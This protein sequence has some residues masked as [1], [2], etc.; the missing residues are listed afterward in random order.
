MALQFDVSIRKYIA[1]N[2]RPIMYKLV[3]A[4]EFIPETMSTSF[5]ARSVFDDVRKEFPDLILKFSSDNPRNP[6][7]QAGPKELEIIKYLNSNPG[8]QKWEGQLTIDGKPYMAKFSAMRMKEECLHCHGEPADAPASLLERY[9]PTAGFHRPLNEVVALDTVAI[10]MDKINNLLWA[11]LRNNIMAIVATVAILFF[12]IVGVFKYLINNRLSMI[13]QHF[14]TTAGQEDYLKIEPLEVKGKD[15]ISSL[16][17]SFN[18]LATKIHNYNVSL[19]DEITERKRVEESLI[20][21]SSFLKS[22]IESLNHPFF[23]INTENYSVLIANE[24]SNFKQFEEEATCY[25]LTHYKNEPCSGKEHP[26]PVKEVKKRRQPVILE[27]IHYDRAG[28][29][30]VIEIHAHPIF[31]SDGSINKIIE[32]TLDITDR[33]K[34]EEEK[35]KL[36]SQLQDALDKVKTLSGF[37]PICASCKKIRDDKGYWSQIEEYIRDHSEAEFSHGICPDCAKKLYPDFDIYPE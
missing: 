13:A 19:Q 25:E 31:E 17:H 33:R 14:L 22:T 7:N 18:T 34:T 9:G 4:D 32:Y 20:E 16:A 6:A 8:L 11:D 30:R 35:E 27:H 10:P 5:V 36:I 1:D 12:F 28:N 37:L 24:A 23:V 21:Q 2:V 15:E 29:E 26:C 3:E